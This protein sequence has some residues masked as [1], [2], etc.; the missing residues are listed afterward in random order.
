MDRNIKQLV[1]A[2]ENVLP[3]CLGKVCYR[4]YLQTEKVRQEDCCR[5]KASWTT[6]KNPFSNKDCLDCPELGLTLS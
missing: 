3:K 4:T 1:N 2:V 5:L 6:H